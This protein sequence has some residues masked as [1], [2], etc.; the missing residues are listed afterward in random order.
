VKQLRIK[1][2]SKCH[3]VGDDDHIVPYPNKK[4]GVILSKAKNLKRK[5]DASPAVAADNAKKLFL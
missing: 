4:V 2:K 3:S 1:K 5:R